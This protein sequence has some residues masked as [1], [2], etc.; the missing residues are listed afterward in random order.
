MFVCQVVNVRFVRGCVVEIDVIDYNV[1]F[2]NYGGV[3]VWVEYQCVIRKIFVLVVVSIVFYFKVN[4]FSE[5]C[6]ERLF[7]IV[8]EFYLYWLWQI[9]VFVNFIDFVR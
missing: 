7:C 4:V 2:W 8:V 9:L 3:M 5:E 1:F 6:F